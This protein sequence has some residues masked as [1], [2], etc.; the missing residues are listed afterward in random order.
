M[1]EYAR[2]LVWA[3]AGAC[4]AMLAAAAGGQDLRVNAFEHAPATDFSSILRSLIPSTEI[5]LS[6]IAGGAAGAAISAGFNPPS[7]PAGRHAVMIALVFFNPVFLGAC[8]YGGDALFLFTASLFVWRSVI[9]HAHRQDYATTVLL[10]G[11]LAVANVSSSYFL[12]TVPALFIGLLMLS[13]WRQT[14]RSA[15]GVSLAYWSPL[16]MVYLTYLYVAWIA[17]DFFPLKAQF[18]FDLQNLA[19]AAPLI[20][21]G[22]IA[23]PSLVT[24]LIPPQRRDND[25][26]SAMIIIAALITGGAITAGAGGDPFLFAV[27]AFA[28]QIAAG[29]DGKGVADGLPFGGLAAAFLTGAAITALSAGANFAFLQ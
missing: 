25:R 3:A 23:A 22:P 26:L 29:G 21:A 24:R 11:A 1:R 5:F 16:I 28:A 2:H 12:F 17:A 19:G 6:A 15:I 14:P 18:G 20:L 9:A 10:G 7:P 27:S 13:P 4:V 8:L